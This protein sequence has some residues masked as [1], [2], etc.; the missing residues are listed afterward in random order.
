MTEDEARAW[1]AARFPADRVAIVDRYVALLLEENRA[2]NL[3]S[4][5]SEASIWSRH[6]VDS[7]QL[8]A[9]APEAHSWLDVGS[10]PGLPGLV[11]ACLS[12]TPIAL[13]EPRIRRVEFLRRAAAQLGLANVT[14]YPCVVERM[15]DGC[16]DVV[17]ARAFAS[18]PEIFASTIRLTGSSTIWVLPKGRSAETELEAAR[19]TWQGV[20]HVEQSATDAEARIVVAR[21]IRRVKR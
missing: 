1:L 19:D 20:F 4:K 12:K 16:Y 18:L 5:A 10:G 9:F 7:A 13:V 17:T 6:I 15:P 11:L 3:I 2:Q 14:V 8:L 21:Q